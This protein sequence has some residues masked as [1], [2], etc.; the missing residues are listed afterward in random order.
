MLPFKTILHPTDFSDASAHALTMAVGLARDYHARLVVLHA[1]E[2]P[3]YYGELG[4]NVVP[5]DD[6][7]KEAEERVAALLGPGC[8]VAVDHLVTEGVAAQEILRVAGEFH[9]ELIVLGSHGRTGIGRVLM[10]SVAEEVARKSPCPV[11]VVRVPHEIRLDET[12]A[13][14][15]PAEAH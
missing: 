9:C 11:L 14:G 4:V 7:R 8:P 2:P 5:L 3:V 12:E 6:Y 1:V 10:G 13:A 15:S